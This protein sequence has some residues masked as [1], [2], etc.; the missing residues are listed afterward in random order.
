MLHWSRPPPALV[1]LRVGEG[2]ARI[3][4]LDSSRYTVVWMDAL[5]IK[6]REHGRT[7]NVDALIAVGV[8]ADGGREVWG[9][10]VASDE[11]GAG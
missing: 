1:R 3:R 2:A 8:N 7:V 10:D 6:V 4:P 5:T 9:L 11:D